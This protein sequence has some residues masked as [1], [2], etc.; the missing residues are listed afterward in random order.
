MSSK[1][2][3]L[4]FFFFCSKDSNNCSPLSIKDQLTEKLQQKEGRFQ[5]VHLLSFGENY[6]SHMDRPAY[7]GL[8]IGT[9]LPSDQVAGKERSLIH[10]VVIKT[11]WDTQDAG[12]I[13]IRLVSAGLRRVVWWIWHQS[14]RSWTA[15][16]CTGLRLRDPHS[17]FTIGRALTV[18]P[19]I[20]EVHLLSCLMPVTNSCHCVSHLLLHSKLFLF[21]WQFCVRNGSAR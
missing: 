20:P 3:K 14:K 5:N 8:I 10:M 12:S 17:S 13:S 1:Q 18:E 19:E 21:S 15:L 9:F 16:K 4:K 11:R 6:S 2:K 7:C